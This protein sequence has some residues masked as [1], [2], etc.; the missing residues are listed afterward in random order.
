MYRRR[1]LAGAVAG[2]AL[3]LAPVSFTAAGVN[4]L[5]VLRARVRPGQAGWPNARAWRQLA[6]QVGGRLS[7][8]QALFAP[9]IASSTGAA[10]ADLKANMRNPFYLGDQ[11]SGTQVSGWL[12]AWTSAPSAY[13]IAARGTADVVAGVNFARTHNLRLVVKGTGHSYQGTSNCADSLLIWTRAMKAIT[14]HDAFVPAGG[15]GKAAPQHA[16]TSESGA[17]WIDLYHAVT[18]LG[19]R[20]VQ[21]GGCTDVGV[22]GLV[23]SGGFGSFS[24]GFGT[25]AANLLEAEIVTADGVARTV[26]AYRDPELFWAIRGGGGGSWGVVTKVTLRTHALPKLF[27]AAWGKIKAGSDAAYLR[28]IDYFLSFY[29]E[30]LFNR[31][32]GEQVA[33]E[34]DNTLTIS[35]VCQGL[36][37]GQA[38]A[39]WQPFIDWVK[40]SAELSGAEEFGVHEGDARSWWSVTDN[41]AMLPDARPGAPSHRG[42]WKG[43]ADQVGVYLHAYDTL[44]MPADLL[45]PARR[46]LLAATLLRASRH[47]KV[48]LHLNKGLAGAPPEAIAA[49]RAT[50]TN[51]A[52]C[53]A[54]ALALIADAQGSAYPGQGKPDLAAA[55]ADAGNI[56]AAAAELHRLVPNA[57]SYVSE[58][59][60][61]NP[62]WREAFWGAHYA[63]LLRVKQRID[64]GCMFFV[65]HGV[66]SE[67]WSADGFTPLGAGMS[68]S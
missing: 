49:A 30:H 13:A 42:W 21:G 40:A 60:Y 68:S 7:Q 12:D 35:M 29:R 66:G 39:L 3:G 14:L 37:K 20:Y 44:W 53:D 32:W 31:H 55:R 46:P 51:G 23:Q 64:P 52:V 47:K 33:F 56:N 34:P 41:G 58:S 18:T 62:R 22:A 59:D 45:D 17:V 26:N 11:S 24:K 54:F 15:A 8:P 9:C 4:P 50:A 6:Q 27:G 1:F 65:H 19:G 28:L 38:R 48:Q 67:A 63:R 2:L 61:F 25:A 16:V 57:G 36:D 43:D 10:C 5:N